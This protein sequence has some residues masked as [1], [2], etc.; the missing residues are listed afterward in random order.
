MSTQ[1]TQA[2]KT[3]DPGGLSKAVYAR[4]VE[5]EPL[6]ASALNAL[7]AAR[8]KAIIEELTTDGAITPERVTAKDPAAVPEGETASAK[9]SLDVAGKS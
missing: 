7:A 8:G 6:E 4:L 5:S 3:D 9:L 1:T 2:E